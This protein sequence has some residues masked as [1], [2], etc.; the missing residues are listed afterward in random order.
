MNIRLKVIALIGAIF[1]IL[2]WAEV[3]VERQV[4][5]PSFAELERTDA[6]TAMRRVNYAL[7]RTL[8]ELA[9][10]AAD[11]GNWAE[12]YRFAGDHDPEFVATNVSNFSMRQLNAN[13]LL[14]VDQDGHVL[15]GYDM[16]LHTDERLHLELTSLAELPPDFPW[17]RDLHATTPA[18][19]LLH[20]KSGILML[21]AAPV[22]NGKGQGPARGMMIIGRLLS[23]EIVR[24]IG[25]QAQVDLERLAA[26]AQSPAE[27]LA[28]D[29]ST[30][31][32][33]Q[34]FQD[35]Y[36]RPI[37]RLQVA[38][39]RSITARGR[40]AVSYASLCLLAA[41]I[42]VLLLLGMVLDRAILRPLALV[43]RHAVALGDDKDLTTR[44]NLRRRDEFGVLAR[45]FDRMVDRV[46]E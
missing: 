34:S 7:E 39:P 4:V 17:R 12:L 46:A 28:E 21:A 6:R 32:I 45:E 15:H 5:M 19:G 29:E 9:M 3:L 30:T 44:L 31:R 2:V 10:L 13:A 33:A 42:I 24:D 41:A 23:P 26:S 25:A 1:A 22:L 20:T 18:P 43:T 37:M 40:I 16:D 14:I 38:V 8:H 11:W 36:G 35:L 27:V